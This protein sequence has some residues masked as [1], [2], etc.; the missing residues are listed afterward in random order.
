[1]DVWRVKVHRRSIYCPSLSM[2]IGLILDS[3]YTYSWGGVNVIVCSMFSVIHGR[4]GPLWI[5]LANHIQQGISRWAVIFGPSHAPFRV[6]ASTYTMNK[7]FSVK[8]SV[9]CS[10]Q[11][12]WRENWKFP[13][14]GKTLTEHLWGGIP[15]LQLWQMML[16]TN[17]CDRSITSHEQLQ[18]TRLINLANVRRPSVRAC[19]WRSISVLLLNV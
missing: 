10:C 11:V 17:M 5:M 7:V 14:G 16:T 9:I 2:Y 6:F 3:H 15:T 18:T 13:R 1:M 19:Q 12:T 4:I 8:V